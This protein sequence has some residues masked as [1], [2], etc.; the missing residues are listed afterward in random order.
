VDRQLI[1]EVLDRRG[2]VVS[3]H[4]ITAFPATVGRGYGC[5]V[6]LDDRFASPE[7]ARIDIEPDGGLAV[8]DL[9]SLNGLRRAGTR[10]RVSRVAIGA[11]TRIRIGQ[12]VL[13]FCF[14]DQ[15]VAP[16]VREKGETLA[17]GGLVLAPAHGLAIGAVAAGWVGLLAFLGSFDGERGTSGTVAVIAMSLVIA[18]WAGIWALLGRLL[19][20]RPRFSLH[21]GL[22]GLAVIVSIVIEIAGSYAEFL[23][24][25]HAAIGPLT[26]TLNV[27]VVGALLAG[28]LSLATALPKATRIAIGFGLSMGLVGLSA[29][30]VSAFESDSDR[31]AKFEGAIKGLGQ[32]WVNA[33]TPDRF[34]AD[35]ERLVAE[36]DELAAHDSSGAP[37]SSSAGSG[38]NP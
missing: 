13:R 7:H 37:D 26:A 2:H 21:V 34:F 38:M 6:I 5:T 30:A 10:D 4:R 22:A 24:P 18:L 23:L 1:V 3:R 15:P 11:G 28:S 12:T 14:P 25:Q 35:V 17:V 16:A 32:R 36:V 19:V 33:A 20:H 9:D 8:V 27:L 31:A 29:L